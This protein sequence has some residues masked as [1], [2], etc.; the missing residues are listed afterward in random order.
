MFA[1]SPTVAPTPITPTGD[2]EGWLAGTGLE[3]AGGMG[4]RVK[5]GEVRMLGNV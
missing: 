3:A 2:P 1:P 5:E 4:W